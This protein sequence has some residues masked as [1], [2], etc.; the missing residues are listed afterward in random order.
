MLYAFC[1]LHGFS[2]GEYYGNCFRNLH[3]SYPQPTPVSISS[4]TYTHFQVE[5]SEIQSLSSWTLR[6]DDWCYHGW[7]VYGVSNTRIR[8]EFCVECTHI[9]PTAT[10][11]REE[12]LPDSFLI[13]VFT[14]SSPNHWK[15]LHRPDQLLQLLNLQDSG[16]HQCSS[17][18]IEPPVFSGTD[19]VSV[20]GYDWEALSS[21]P[22]TSKMKNFINKK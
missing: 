9:S 18:R 10:H 12:L 17:Q 2:D 4:F 8:C 7:S 19:I 16:I 3:H 13:C 6:V 21:S 15:H 1:L 22:W 20:S 14:T 11:K 5:E